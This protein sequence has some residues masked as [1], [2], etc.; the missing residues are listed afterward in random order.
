MA[1]RKPPLMICPLKCEN[2]PKNRRGL[3]IVQSKE[4]R[5][6]TFFFSFVNF[7]SIG[8]SLFAFSKI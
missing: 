4:D 6:E 2:A 8:S 3:A 1:E 7:T 5:N